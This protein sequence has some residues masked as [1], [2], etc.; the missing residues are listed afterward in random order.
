MKLCNAFLAFIHPLEENYYRIKFLFKKPSNFH[1]KYYE[2]SVLYNYIY[3][4]TSIKLPN[5]CQDF[6]PGNSIGF[7]FESGYFSQ[8]A[9]FIKT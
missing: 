9:L 4:T 1:F 8:L 5:E 2:L 3:E 6:E 7:K